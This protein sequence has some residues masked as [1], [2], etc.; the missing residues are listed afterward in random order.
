MR[1]IAIIGAGASGLF[2]SK[3]LSEHADVQVYVFEKCKHVG[4]KLRASG[5]G[6]A[7]I[8][9]EHLR[10]DCYNQSQW[11][12]PLLEQVSASRLRS[13]FDRMGLALVTDEEGRVYPSTQF[14]QT[15]VD[16]LSTA[17]CPQVHFEMEYE[18]RQLVQKN[19]KWQINDYPI[20]FDHVVIATGT[21]ANMIAKNR[22]G[23]NGFLTDFNLKTNPFQPSLVGFK[24]ASY[25]K[26]LSGCRTKVIASLYQGNRLIHEE[27]GE[28][29]FKDDGIS[30]I[31]ILNLSAYYH[32]LASKENCYLQLNLIYHQPDY[33]IEQHL[34]Q[35]HTLKGLLHPKLNDLYNQQPF[36]VKRYK[37]AI[38]D[39]YEIEYAQV[40]HGGID[41]C[42]IDTQFALKRFPGLFVTGELLDVDGLCGGYN[43]Y[44]AFAS[45]LVVAEHLQH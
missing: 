20:R 16:I 26:Q 1:H 4:T 10:P 14:S 37:L 7:N 9:N 36:D 31:V 8:F 38:L 3:K 18:V 23:Y 40:C 34:Q 27:A 43:L 13:E 12:A 35:F 39:T 45:A 33:N 30:G 11:I 41:L 25:P 44:F 6:K 32:R 21:P 5:G 15:V 2:L 17:Y 28:V 42:E 24:I 19:G 29:T 22:K